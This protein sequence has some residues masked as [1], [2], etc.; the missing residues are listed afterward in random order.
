MSPSINITPDLLGMFK[1]QVF[2]VPTRVAKDLEALCHDLDLLQNSG[3]TDLNALSNCLSRLSDWLKNQSGSSLDDDSGW[4]SEP[5]GL[6][7]LGGMV[8][9]RSERWEVVFNQ[10]GN[11]QP[12][13]GMWQSRVPG[14]INRHSSFKIQSSAGQ[15]QLVLEGKRSLQ[16][17]LPQFET[18]AWVSMDAYSKELNKSHHP[19]QP[20][21][22][23]IPP[24]SIVQEK[25]VPPSLPN[26]LD[27]E[28]SPNETPTI[29]AAPRKS[30][31]PPAQPM[32]CK[33]CGTALSTDARFCR[34]CGTK[35]SR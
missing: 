33:Q 2:P 31:N 28:L 12:Y 23:Q 19:N 8:T 34:N 13:L 17:F 26:K 7:G 25:T 10:D 24:A 1:K 3:Q 27:V 15:I 9:C 16:V 30:K 20:E 18:A 21:S 11:G 32:F 22:H 4:T 29:L 35:V 6:K 14:E 5:F